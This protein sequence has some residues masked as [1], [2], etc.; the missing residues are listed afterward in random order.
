MANYRVGEIIRLTRLAS[1]MTQEELCENIC[2]VETLSRIENGKHRVKQDVYRKFME[3]MGKMTEKTY[4]VCVSEDMELIE[5]R[6]YFE[7]AM[8]KHDYI[9]ADAY[10]ELIRKKAGTS[11][12]TSQYVRR[13]NAFLEFYQ[14]KISAEEL[15]DILEELAQE[16]I[17]GYEKYLNSE[18]IYPFMEQELILLKR[19]SVAYSFNKEREK[20]IQICEMLL[21][22][23]DKEYIVET[24]EMKISVLGNLTKYYGEM[25]NHKK[26]IEIGLNNLKLAKKYDDGAAITFSLV[27]L[28]W[29]MI[30]EIEE[31]IR[32]KE[33]LKECRK[34]LKKAYYLA[35][36]R[37]DSEAVIISDF[38]NCYFQETID[39]VV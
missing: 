16:V 12:L 32:E 20:S 38:Y 9:K 1:G 15:V 24:E 35:S 39:P 5:E 4:A 7:D 22:T 36:A 29:D 6:A 18:E 37:N 26:A 8:R 34:Y 10:M 3:R 14:K 11:V 28:A 23:L 19:L 17:P 21:G 25:R 27:E 31:G 30:K 33:Y 2:S 13:E